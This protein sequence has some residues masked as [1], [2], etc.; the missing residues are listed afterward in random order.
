LGEALNSGG[1]L[2]YGEVEICDL[3][4]SGCFVCGSGCFSLNAVSVDSDLCCGCLSQDAFALGFEEVVFHLEL[5][6]LS[7][8]VT[9]VL[10][11]L[12]VDFRCN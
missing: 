2:I 4:I 10:L 8:Q 5:L 3:H 7:F 11:P 12:G 6:A 1:K 9:L